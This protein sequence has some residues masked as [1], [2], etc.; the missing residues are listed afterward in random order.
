[1][2]YTNTCE[3]EP[4]SQEF[5]EEVR[6]YHQRRDYCPR[7]RELKVYAKPFGRTQRIKELAGEATIKAMKVNHKAI[8]EIEKFD[9]EI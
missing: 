6:G 1:M 2:K 8:K 7:C 4:C 3:F 5:T 9:K